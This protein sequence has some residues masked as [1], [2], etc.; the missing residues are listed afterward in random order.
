MI[1]STAGRSNVKMAARFAYAATGILANVFLI[2]FFA[3]RLE[4]TSAWPT[5]LSVR[6]GVR[7]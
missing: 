3:L 2:A 1:S 4:H 6:L 5:T 7:S